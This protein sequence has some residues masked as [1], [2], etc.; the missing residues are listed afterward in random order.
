[1]RL[2]EPA[3]RLGRWTRACAGSSQTLLIFAVIVDWGPTVGS[4]DLL[5]ILSDLGVSLVVSFGLL[6]LVGRVDWT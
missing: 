4:G 3:S 2:S 5:G 6:L 1:M